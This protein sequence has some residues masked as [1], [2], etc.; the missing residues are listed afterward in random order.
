MAGIGFEIKKILRTQA[1]NQVLRAY[2]YAGVIAAGPWV[3]S[4]SAIVVIYVLSSSNFVDAPEILLKFQA[5]I[6]YLISISL[7]LSGFLQY[8]FTR[9]TADILFDKKERWV[10]ANGIGS[11]ILMTV[12]SAIAGFIFSYF[13]LKNTP[14]LYR[15]I[16]AFTMVIL[17]NI[18]LIAN[19]LSGLKAYKSI[20][21]GFFV[22]YGVS[23][24]GCYYGWH[25][26]LSGM[27]VGFIIG[28]IILFLILLAVVSRSYFSKNILS[29]DF[30]KQGKMY[31]TLIFSGLFYNLGIW[32]D[33]YWFWFYPGTGHHVIGS[34]NASLIY[35]LPMF[36][37]FL[38]II[39]GFSVFLFR[40]E[41]DFV[42]Y[43]E[44]Y[45][46]AIRDG[47]SLN[48]INAMHG[49]MV[50]SVQV[51]L[52]DIV[53]IQALFTAIGFIYSGSIL[54]FFNFPL[55]QA[56]LFRMDMLAIDFLVLFIAMLN[57]M[58]YLDKRKQAL[59]LT[60]LFFVLNMLLTWLTLYLGI[61]FYGYGLMVAL[62][63]VDLTALL[64]LNRN[65]ERLT[66]ETFMQ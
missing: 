19:L 53:K 13:F 57:V 10:L 26:G 59:F 9:Y 34:L 28:Q 4:L 52:L 51:G 47:G 5:S 1:L 31:G 29:Y 18:W 24:L 41:T 27:M 12:A 32:A 55:I 62:I 64:L 36:L 60:A 43:Y 49:M 45:Y 40:M 58:F 8:A 37:S 44:S 15:I 11:L 54:S 2:C 61:H 22:G 50:Q 46:L 35:D 65:F 23:I 48:K 3:I 14:L 17:S 66:Y 25:Y 20:L 39:P 16:C 63:V 56:H 21:F 42:D 38:L 6:T 33:K 30:S 7:I